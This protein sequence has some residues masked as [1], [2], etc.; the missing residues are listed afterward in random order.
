M[1]YLRNLSLAAITGA[2][3]ITFTGSGRQPVTLEPVDPAQF[4]RV[5]EL[6]SR[7]VERKQLLEE[8]DGDALDA[9]VAAGIV[10]EGPRNKLLALRQP[11]PKGRPCRHLVVGVTGAINA[12]NVMALL[13][14]LYDRFC[15]RLDVIFTA[16]AL[17]FVNPQALTYLGIGCWTDAFAPQ[18]DATVPH[19]HLARSAELV[20]VMPA[21]A[22]SLQRLASGACSDL[23]SLVV[24]AT[25][26]PV[27]V[28]PSM[29][30]AM[31]SNPAIQRNVQQLRA[32][33]VH[34]IEPSLAFEVSDRHQAQPE[35]GG[36]GLPASTAIDALTALLPPRTRAPARKR[37]R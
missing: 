20:A 30:H 10:L 13:P 3:S 12:I 34:V 1:A 35:H 4:S 5:L 7:P 2:R 9:L 21:S 15:E 18:G 28:A 24:A 17:R 11:L 26:A 36:M 27:A 23:L 32:G 22:S 6:L 14:V 29:N 8:V 37:R 31:W 16:S 19:I 33:G 25:R